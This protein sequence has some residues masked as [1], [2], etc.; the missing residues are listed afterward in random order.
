MVYALL[1]EELAGSVHALALHTYTE[2]Q[3]QALAEAPASP[4]CRG[5][6]H[7]EAGAAGGDASAAA[8]A[9]RG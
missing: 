9:G 2:A 6:M 4:A 8:E 1:A 3:W 7:G 5:G